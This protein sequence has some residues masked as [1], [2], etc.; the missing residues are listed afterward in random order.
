MKLLR[1]LY[2]GQL[3]SLRKNVHHTI[4]VLDF[5][6][7]EDLS[8]LVE[9]VTTL[10]KRNIPIR[11]G[12]V[13]LPEHGHV[14]GE[15]LA[16]IF[17]HLIDT[18]G[19]AIA[20]KFAEEFLEAFNPST[21]SS[22]VKT[23][24]K[25]VTDKATPIA[26]HTKKSFE[27]LMAEESDVT[28]N[29]RSWASRLGIN[30][31]EGAIIGNGNLFV[32]DD[33]W[34]NRV[35]G[36]LQ[37][38]TRILQRAVYEGEISDT[39]D[40]LEYLFRHVPKR[41][42]KYVFPADATD[43]RMINLVESLPDD[44]IVYIHGSAGPSPGVENSM[45]IW[46]IDDLDSFSGV[47]LIKSAAS[48][49]VSQPQITIGLVH[50]PGPTTGPPNL[51]LL[52]YHLAK[53]GLFAEPAATERFQELIREVDLTTHEASDETAKLLGFKAE[54]WRTPDSE[55]ARQFWEASKAFIKSAGVE[56]GQK[57]LVVNGR[58]NGFAMSLMTGNRAIQR[59]R[60]L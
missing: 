59:G 30:P 9:E 34:M 10:I 22:K 5:A 12:I 25:S 48:F 57:A 16:R 6:K 14:V 58:V 60:Q 1:Q 7:K 13:A 21:F 47:E 52:L 18:Y 37:E 36:Q 29:A 8:R 24:F 15:Q 49:M 4:F 45:V 56:A 55:D 50:N 46:I 53:Q 32:K 2:P 35:G 43:L 26:S 20:M 51:S 41:R 3:H 11:F 40:I 39:D 31:K 23:L 19:R 54:S 38:D 44:G 42:N 17:Y 28:V 27:E 33:Q